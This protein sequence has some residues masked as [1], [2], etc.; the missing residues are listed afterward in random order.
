MSDP[1]VRLAIVLT[2][3]GAAMGSLLDTEDGFVLQR[4]RILSIGPLTNG[5]IQF[6]F[7]ELI[8]KPAE[9]VV[10]GDLTYYIVTDQNVTKTYIEAISSIKIAHTLP[11]RSTIN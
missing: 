1:N 8:G 3:S 7:S 11:P 6:Q 9:L 2:P 4:P 10:V 5:M